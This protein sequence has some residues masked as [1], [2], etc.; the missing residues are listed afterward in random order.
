MLRQKSNR[1]EKS[2]SRMRDQSRIKP[3]LFD[4]P[5]KLKLKIAPMADIFNGH[6]ANPDLSPFSR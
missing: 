4:T 3:Q 5:V 6:F 1:E 2:K